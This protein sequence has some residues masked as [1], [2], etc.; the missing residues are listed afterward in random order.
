MLKPLNRHWYSSGV[1]VASTLKATGCPAIRMA[2]TG[3]VAIFGVPCELRLMSRSQLVA[4]LAVTRKPCAAV[5]LGSLGL[6]APP[7]KVDVT[8]SPVALSS[9]A[10]CSPFTAGKAKSAA[11]P[12]AIGSVAVWYDSPLGNADERLPCTTE[13]V[14]CSVSAAPVL[15]SNIAAWSGATT[16]PASLHASP[17]VL[18]F[19]EP[20][21]LSQIETVSLAGPSGSRVDNV[22]SPLAKGLD[23]NDLPMGTSSSWKPTILSE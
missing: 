1:P 3:W 6:H 18:A 8:Q 19:H 15:L 23:S 4:A 13:P 10:T 5:R 16:S 7:E 21:S 12:P 2:P 11:K 14:N 20:E 17:N 22:F 9:S